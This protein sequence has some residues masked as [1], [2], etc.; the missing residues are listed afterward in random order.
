VLIAGWI[1]GRPMGVAGAALATTLSIAIGVVA[2][3]LYFVKLEHYIAFDLSQWRPK[4]ATWARILNIGL[5]AGGEF[6][7]MAI[8]IGVMYWV[9]RDFGA[10]AQAGFGVGLRIN[11][12]IFVPAIA[13]AFAA[14]PIAGQNFGARSAARVRETFRIAA[15]YGVLVMILLTGLVQW[16]AEAFARLFTSEP[17]VI[18][19][20][21]E[22]LRYI[23]WNFVGVGIAHTCSALFQAMGNA[24]PSF[25]S[26][27]LRIVIFALPA[28]WMARQPWFE[29]HHVF[30]LSVA[31]VLVQAV[32]SYLWLR[33]EFAR[34]LTFA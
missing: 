2:M 27:G 33:R 8:F 14:M 20:C 32:V 26:S 7:F 1:T 30:M 16:K 28:V 24:W 6:A 3:A 31:T 17:E 25:A 34:R 23:S 4:L 15:T 22:Y 5:P 21:V 12:M 11:Q 18:A 29:L 13:I 10:A 9:M 19:V